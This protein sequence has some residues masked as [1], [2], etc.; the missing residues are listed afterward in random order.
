M[1]KKFML[2][3]TLSENKVEVKD[4][5]GR[6][7]WRIVANQEGELYILGVG[8]VLAISPRGRYEIDCAMAAAT[9][10]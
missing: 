10:A 3:V 1:T 8:E 5:E 9:D 2:E 4:R 7:K 6:L